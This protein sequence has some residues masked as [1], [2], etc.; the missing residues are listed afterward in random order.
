[1][2]RDREGFPAGINQYVPGMQHATEVTLHQ[3]TM[4]T[5][6]KPAASAAN[7]VANL[8]PANTI[9]GT[10][11][12]YTWTSDARYGRLL[13]YTPSAVPGNNNVIDIC[14]TDYLG[15]PLVERITGA[16]A[17][18]TLIAGKKAFYRVTHAKIVTAAT[19]A[20]T[21]AIGTANG[22]GLPFKGIVQYAFEA[23]LPVAVTV[24]APD[25]TDPATGATGDPRGTLTPV[26]APNGVIEYAVMMLGN[27][28]V[29][30]AGNGGLH[31]IRHF[32]G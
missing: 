7:S 10:T 14:G 19:N 8:V 22:L 1:M 27:P 30:A 26:G 12:F 15:Q 2:F 13:S 18:A 9:A 4:F 29:N 5:I 20:I 11:T 23:G 3:P 25:L 16:A 28:S 6:G 24:V 31:G 32:G 17:A 21:F